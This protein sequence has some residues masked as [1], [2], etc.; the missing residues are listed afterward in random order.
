M[1][2]GRERRLAGLAGLL[3]AA[4]MAVEPDMEPVRRIFGDNAGKRFRVRRADEHQ[5]A[6]FQQLAEAKQRGFDIGQMLDDVVANDEVETA[7]REA[8]DLNVAE[9]RLLRVVVVADLIRIDIDHRDAGATQ[10]VERQEAG[11]AA[12][13]FVDPE[14]GRW[15]LPGENAVNGE[16]AVARLA[17]RQR[18]QCLRMLD[19]RGTGHDTQIGRNLGRRRASEIDGG[20]FAHLYL[21]D[22]DV[23]EFGSEKREPEF[24]A[25]TRPGDV[26]QPAH[27]H[28]AGEANAD[29]DDAGGR[30]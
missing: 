6:L 16:Q 24:E 26:E 12:A 2:E 22:A 15:Q 30:V 27:G 20:C 3:L 5:S 19:R 17:G 21:S 23:G 1:E 18:E 4:H 29:Q 9:D 28:V 25:P 10:H 11:R 14:L 13:G 7:R 8:V